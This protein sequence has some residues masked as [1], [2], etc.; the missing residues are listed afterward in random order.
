MFRLIKSKKYDWKQFSN[1]LWMN[2]DNIK[3][4]SDEGH[5][6]GMHSHSHSTYIDRLSKE[7]QFN[8][9]KTNKSILEKITNKPIYCMS[10]PCGKYSKSSLEVLTDLNI[11]IGFIDNMFFDYDNSNLLIPRE[12]HTNIMKVVKAI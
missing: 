4:L 12:D 2:E 7:E 8:D 11:N 3:N 9:Y 6:I 5:I 1:K 10:H